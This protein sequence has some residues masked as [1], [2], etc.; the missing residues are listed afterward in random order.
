MLIPAKEYQSTKMIIRN[1]LQSEKA[2]N[3]SIY[4]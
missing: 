4:Q 3:S 2:K 1:H